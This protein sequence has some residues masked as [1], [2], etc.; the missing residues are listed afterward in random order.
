MLGRDRHQAGLLDRYWSMLRRN[1]RAIPPAGLDPDLA[2]LAARLE[3]NLAAP[4]PT[5]AYAESMR[6]RLTV[7]AERLVAGE[8]IDPSSRPSS[9][10]RPVGPRPMPPTQR[11]TRE[12]DLM[13]SQLEDQTAADAPTSLP[14]SPWYQHYG[15]IAAVFAIALLAGLA[16]AL[17]LRNTSDE[18][19]AAGQPTP[20]PTVVPTQPVPTT[21]SSEVFPTVVQLTV[22]PPSTATVSEVVPTV[23]PTVTHPTVVGSAFSI[24]VPGF[25]IPEG[26]AYL[27]I[28]SSSWAPFGGSDENNVNTAPG[29]VYQDTGSE[30]CWVSRPEA[31]VY[32]ADGSTEES[33]STDISAPTII[34]T[35][36]AYTVS[37]NLGMNCKNNTTTRTVTLEGGVFTT[38]PVQP[39]QVPAGLDYRIVAQ[40][41]TLDLP[42]GSATA[43]L[44]RIVLKP[45]AEVE[46][47][48]TAWSLVWVES[49]SVRVIVDGATTD[50]GE[51]A[52]IAIP[53]GSPPRF[54]NIS[55]STTTLIVFSLIPDTAAALATSQPF[56]FTASVDS[57]PEGSDYLTIERMTWRSFGGTDENETLN[58][59]ALAYQDS[60]IWECFSAGNTFSVI[61][62]DGQI[63]PMSSDLSAPSTI[64]AGD[65][66]LAPGVGGL[67]CKNPAQGDATSISLNVYRGGTTGGGGPL[68]GGVVQDVLTGGPLADLTAGPVMLTIQRIIVAAG[69][70]VPSLTGV[71]ALVF[72]EDGGLNLRP[73]TGDETVTR[74]LRSSS[75]TVPAGGET[76]LQ[77]GDGVA[78][79]AHSGAVLR[80]VSAEPVTV[81]VA[82][83]AP[84]P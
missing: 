76:D 54:E 39:S 18:H 37:A 55:G 52:S 60:G 22:T 17:I 70:S 58:G 56:T 42:A 27:D 31:P 10:N 77:A 67:N 44:E 12:Y 51:P 69:E 59:P 65:G 19:Q 72:I 64:P 11:Q 45:D 36:D 34:S 82:T 29:L 57:L 53:A 7:Q 38:A 74:Q 48:G 49:G 21:T 80:N 35:G 6:R 63:E 66:F 83:V 46:G 14:R 8:S 41:S 23:A 84:A 16:L 4:A 2:D 26:A 50:L 5:S 3:R 43:N 75:E 78:L 9:Q 81:L 25:T 71:D 30:A 33:I 32:R 13:Q 28:E 79:P 15:R 68:P 1:R 62:A 20:S 73:A 24:S 61:R 40:S 47:D